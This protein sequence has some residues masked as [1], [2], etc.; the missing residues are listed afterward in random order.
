MFGPAFARATRSALRQAR[1]WD[2]R[3]LPVAG[4][5]AAH[6]AAAVRLL[7]RVARVHAGRLFAGRRRWR[8]ATQ[9]SAVAP[10]GASAAVFATTRRHGRFVRV[11]RLRVQEKLGYTSIVPT[12]SRLCSFARLCLCLWQHSPPAARS[13]ESSSYSQ[14]SDVKSYTTV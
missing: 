1:H 4:H 2:R 13:I 6:A 3:T 8:M 5:A 11:R 14:V 12:S 10:D 7:H 9:T